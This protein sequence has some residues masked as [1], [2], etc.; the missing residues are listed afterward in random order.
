[1]G[2]TDSN[3]FDS[4]INE[5]SWVN[6]LDQTMVGRVRSDQIIHFDSSRKHRKKIFSLII[7]IYT[8]IEARHK[9]WLRNV[10]VNNYWYTYFRKPVIIIIRLT[11][12]HMG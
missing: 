5:L 10:Q 11:K 3:F 8:Q 4:L 1:V 2:Q 7:N 6:S 9:K 12:I